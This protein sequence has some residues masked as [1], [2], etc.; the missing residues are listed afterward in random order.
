[1]SF[2]W[3]DLPDM[4]AYIL[5]ADHHPVKATKLLDWARW[6]ADFD[7]RRV[8]TDR[9]KF[10]EV[11][12][13]FLGVDHS[14]GKGRPPLLFETMVFERQRKVKEIFGRL[15]SVREDVDQWRYASWDDA[16]TGHQAVLRRLRKQ[17][18]DARA[19]VKPSN[20]KELP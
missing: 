7:N 12:T 16:L 18:A 2:D 9:T 5:D 10:F 1:M 11:S 20:V 19:L 15:M 4:G 6:C 8:A 14:F 3:D 13:V 17:E